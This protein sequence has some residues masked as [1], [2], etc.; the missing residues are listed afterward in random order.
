MTKP[1]KYLVRGL[2]IDVLILFVAS[3]YLLVSIALS[4][5]G[6]CGVFWFFGGQGRPCTRLE[7]LKEELAFIL[8]PLLF[9]FWWLILLLFIAIPAIGYLIGRRRESRST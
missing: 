9:Y 2:I 7:Y 1:L 3:L 5:K 6:R 4:Y 8:I